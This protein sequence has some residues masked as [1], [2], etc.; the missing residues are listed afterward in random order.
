MEGVGAPSRLGVTA[1]RD[2]GTVVVQSVSHLSRQPVSHIH[3]ASQ[4]KSLLLVAKALCL[5]SLFISSPFSQMPTSRKG[6]HSVWPSSIK[7]VA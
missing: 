6:Q 7:V 1:A 3:S 5:P 4:S 2:V